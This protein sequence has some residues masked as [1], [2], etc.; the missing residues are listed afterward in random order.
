MERVTMALGDDPTGDGVRAC[1]ASVFAS[2]DERPRPL[3]LLIEPVG[4]D[5][6]VDLAADGALVFRIAGRRAV[7]VDFRGRYLAE[8]EVPLA[9]SRRRPTRLVLLPTS[10]NRVKVRRAHL[11]E[12]W[13]R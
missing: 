5:T 1:F 12:G 11:W 4:R 7:K 6:A 13:S 3:A 9:L 10:G 8:H 2:L